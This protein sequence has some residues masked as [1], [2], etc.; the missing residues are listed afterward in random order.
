MVGV[1]DCAPQIH[2]CLHRTNSHTSRVWAPVCAA[3]GVARL[4]NVLTLTNII[5]VNGGIS[6][7]TDPIEVRLAA[8]GGSRWSCLCA[9]NCH[10]CC[11]GA[12]PL[13]ARR[14]SFVSCCCMAG[15]FAK[16]LWVGQ[17]QCVSVMSDLY[18]CKAGGVA[19]FLLPDYCILCCV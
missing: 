16:L 6:T 8:L 5:L 3:G 15:A 4:N 2:P 7:G 18:L 13:W 19:L 1:V 17:H 10:A 12:H 11:V 14:L 9:C